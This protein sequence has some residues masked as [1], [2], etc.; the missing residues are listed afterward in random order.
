MLAPMKGKTI[1]CSAISGGGTARAYAQVDS[2][3][4]IYSYCNAGNG[5]A[6]GW[7]A[8]LTATAASG[9]YYCTSTVTATG[10]SG[11]FQYGAVTATY[12]NCSALWPLN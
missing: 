11:L 12:T 7:V 1:V 8:G 3:G 9:G 5:V 2:S 6:S 4:T 10:V